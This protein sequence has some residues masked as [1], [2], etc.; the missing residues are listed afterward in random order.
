MI[1][2][3]LIRHGE[4]VLTANEAV[5]RGQTD[6]D[7]T[8]KGWQQMSDTLAQLT[9]QQ[10][11]WQAV[12]SSPLRRC[13][14]FAR[15]YAQQQQLPFLECAD[16]QE[17]YFGRWEGKKI[18]DIH[19]SYPQQLAQFWQSP[20]QFVPPQAETMIHFAE[21]IHATLLHLAQWADRQHYQRL[22]IFSHGGVI[23]YCYCL[24]HQKPLDNILQ[25]P[26]DL[27]KAHFFQL[28]LN[29]HG[30]QLSCV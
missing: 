19:Q 28:Q 9:A 14:Q 16:L 2:I 17:F 25:M 21:R 12:I 30:I 29:N 22:L 1:D 5:F 10:R 26:A 20:T 8:P 27:G 6:D 3:C 15:H 18:V 11:T 24:A 4:T 13:V 23:K 7:L